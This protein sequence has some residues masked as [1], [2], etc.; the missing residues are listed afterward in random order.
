MTRVSLAIYS[1]VKFP[2]IIRV[3]AETKKNLWVG[4]YG[5]TVDLGA[6]CCL[7]LDSVNQMENESLK[8]I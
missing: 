8:Y 7:R 6:R 3:T 2:G 5:L 4:R 1:T